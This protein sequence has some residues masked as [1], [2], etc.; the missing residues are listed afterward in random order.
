MT[1]RTSMA[2]LVAGRVLWTLPLLMLSSLS[3]FLLVDRAGDPLAQ[4]RQQ[5]EVTREGLD[6]RRRE[7]RLDDPVMV[8]YVR[9]AKHAVRGDFGRT[10]GGRDVAAMVRQR[11][12]VT[13]RLIGAALLIALIA[14]TVVG[15]VS[16]VRAHSWLDNA[17]TVTAVVALSL[18]IFWLGGVFKELLAVRLNGLLHRQIVFTVGEADPNLTGTLLERLGNYAGHLV[19]P[20]LTLAV[21]LAAVWS[22]YVRSSLIEVL[23][24]E[25]IQAARAKGLS[26][27]R[28]AVRHGLP[29]ALIP[30][31]TVVAVDFGQLIGGAVV[32]EQVFAWR[33]MGSM[34]LEGISTGDTNMVL[35]WLMVTAV[36]VLTLNLLADIAV[37][38]LDPRVR[39]D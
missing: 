29:N 20:T 4:L 38:R 32:L 1:P 16:A 11:L 21:V 23:S 34:L 22:R 33:G 3:V 17:L 19:L 6:A 36:L 24:R 13:L 7:L 35:A 37:G 28:V 12:Q 26:A 18:P 15:T 39:L 8:R 30:F 2:R 27:A 14:A 10:Q 5:P 25:H 31:T 9:W